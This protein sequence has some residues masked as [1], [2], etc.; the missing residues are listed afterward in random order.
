MGEIPTLL[1]CMAVQVPEFHLQRANE[2]VVLSSF[3][4]LGVQKVMYK[5]ENR[6]GVGSGGCFSE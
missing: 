5:L 1:A 6:V 4:G 2:E 3:F